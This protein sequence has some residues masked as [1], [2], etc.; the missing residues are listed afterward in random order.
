MRPG[1]S[2]STP[3]FTPPLPMRL[4]PQKWT[5][6]HWVTLPHLHTIDTGHGN[7]H[8][9]QALGH[10]NV[11]KGRVLDRCRDQLTPHYHAAAHSRRDIIQEWEGKHLLELH[12]TRRV[13]WQSLCLWLTPK[14][15]LVLWLILVLHPSFHF[16]TIAR[17]DIY[18]SDSFMFVLYYLSSC[19]FASCDCT[20]INLIDKDKK[21]TDGFCEF[22]Q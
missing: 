9:A 19:F 17:I 13:R 14:L 1:A 8:S 22:N 2:I 5:L 16:S 20:N 11:A 18:Y 21:G 10:W 3:V 4:T 12:S 7:P 15:S 6:L